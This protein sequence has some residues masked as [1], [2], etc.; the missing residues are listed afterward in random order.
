MDTE[1]KVQFLGEKVIELNERVNKLCRVLGIVNQFQRDYN[2]QHNTEIDN[3]LEWGDNLGTWLEA[4]LKEVNYKY[5]D[6]KQIRN[7]LTHLHNEIHDIQ[8]LLGIDGSM[9]RRTPEKIKGYKQY[10]NE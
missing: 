8:A 10:S 2:K 1:E 9:P 5:N 4:G 6:L 7:E 3:I